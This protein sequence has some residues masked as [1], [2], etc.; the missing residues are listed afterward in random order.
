MSKAPTRDPQQGDVVYLKYRNQNIPLAVEILGR[1]LEING[2]AKEGQA[3][4]R[5]HNGTVSCHSLRDLVSVTKKLVI[6]LHDA[7]RFSRL[8][9]EFEGN[10]K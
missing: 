9:Q 8:I 7:E 10:D 4:V 6:A 5:W 2:H 3:S 1:V